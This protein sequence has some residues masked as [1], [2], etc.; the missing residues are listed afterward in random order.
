MQTI[1]NIKSIYAGG[2]CGGGENHLLFFSERCSDLAEA[3][4]ICGSCNVQMACLA[5][6]LER[7]EDWGVWGGVIFWDGEPFYRRRGRGRPRK[8]ESS[9]PIEANRAELWQ[10]VRSA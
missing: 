4:K 9:L 10:L 5:G 2:A 7:R 1:H 3:Q 6:A 8:N